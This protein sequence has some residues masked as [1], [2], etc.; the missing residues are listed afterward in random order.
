MKPVAAMIGALLVAAATAGAFD[1]VQTFNDV[2]DLGGQPLNVGAAS[3]TD[4]TLGPDAV[5]TG[6]TAVDIAPAWSPTDP[7]H[8][9]LTVQGS[10]GAAAGRTGDVSIGRAGNPSAELLIDGGSVY[11]GTVHFARG[12]GAASLT[13]TGGL[14]DAAGY[15][16]GPQANGGRVTILQEGGTINWGTSGGWAPATLGTKADSAATYTIAGGTSTF[17]HHLTLAG[18][19]NA[20][21]RL[22]LQGSDA[23]LEARTRFIMDSGSTVA[24][25]LDDGAAHINPIITPLTYL[26]AGVIDMGFVDGAAWRPGAGEAFDL[27]TKTGGGIDISALALAA[28][29]AGTW[30]LQVNDA[31]DT[32]QAV[33]LVPEPATLSLLSLGLAALATRRKR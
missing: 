4:I 12:T 28:D 10:L 7:F 9:R 31:G 1:G 11:C 23:F 6:V 24:F 16:N 3:E 20:T 33:Y 32:L 2:R 15:L 18:G 8:A 25:L 19:A 29:D 26:N 27:I 5:W 22:E 30:Q 14:L 21:A 17:Y 13:M